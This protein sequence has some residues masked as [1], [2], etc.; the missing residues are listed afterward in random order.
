MNLQSK[1]LWFAQLSHQG[2]TRG[3]GET[4]YVNHVMQVYRL[5]AFAGGS[6][7][8]LTAALLHDT[9]EDCGVT[10]RQLVDEFG[11]EVANLVG[12]VTFPAGTPNR[13]KLQV[14][15][16]RGMTSQARLLK[17]ADILANVHDLPSARWDLEKKTKCLRHLINMRNA[18]RGTHELLEAEFDVIA[19]AVTDILSTELLTVALNGVPEGKPMRPSEGGV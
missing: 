1:A 13:K 5:V 18:L 6:E 12:E 9:I 14:E 8:A 2:Q 19:L 17:L 15:S 7:A 11:S 4:P 10:Y 16:V 3:D